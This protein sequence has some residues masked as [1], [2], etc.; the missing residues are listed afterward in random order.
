MKGWAQ[1]CLQ[2]HFLMFLSKKSNRAANLSQN[3]RLRLA[4]ATQDKF[5]KASYQAR[6]SEALS[7]VLSEP[8][9]K[10]RPMT[11]SGS[12]LLFQGNLRKRL[13]GLFG[14]AGWVLVGQIIV[15][16]AALASVR[17]LTEL[18]PAA[19]YGQFVLLMGLITLSF[20]LACRNVMQ[21]GMRFRAEYSTPAETVLLRHVTTRIRNWAMLA[22]IFLMAI[23]GFF[24]AE[25]WGLPVWIGLLMGFVFVSDVLRTYET[26]LLNAARRP[27][28]H[29]NLVCNRSCR[30]PGRSG[31]NSVDTWGRGRRQY[32]LP[33]VPRLSPYP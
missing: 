19:Q 15:A 1:L 33:M 31:R 12:S 22:A 29:V 20:G 23:G 18:L 28:N 6:V 30:A 11:L 25:N 24:F 17:L 21:A 32:Y 7:Q 3:D 10:T 4:E 13:E 9:F 27:E 8:S 26:S 5:G 14:E 2:T 16:L